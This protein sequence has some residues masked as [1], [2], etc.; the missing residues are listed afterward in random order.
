MNIVDAYGFFICIPIHVRAIGFF[1][2]IALI[3]LEAFNRNAIH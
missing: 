1:K 2:S 3:F